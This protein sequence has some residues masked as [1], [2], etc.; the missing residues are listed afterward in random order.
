[1]TLPN[2]PPVLVADD[3]GL[4][5]ILTGA[6]AIAVIGASADPARPSHE[7]MAYLQRAGY[8]VVPVNPRAQRVLGVPAVASLA[9]AAPPIDLACVFRRPAEVEAHVD[10]AIAAGVAVLW[11]QL[12]VVAPAA[13]A[14]AARA[15]LRVVMDRCIAVE[16]ARLLRG[17]GD[18]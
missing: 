4:R 13:A 1:M 10:E 14:R 6:R 8:R 5:A 9:A 11:L 7:V 3:A 12:G 17:R 2:D 15:G 16:H 18:R